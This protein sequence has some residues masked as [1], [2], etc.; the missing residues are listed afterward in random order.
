ME[1]RWLCS[2]QPQ[3][4]AHGEG[5]AVADNA[6]VMH[7]GA[8]GATLPC[9]CWSLEAR[10]DQEALGGTKRRSLGFYEVV[11]VAIVVVVIVVPVAIRV[12]EESPYLLHHA[13]AQVH[14]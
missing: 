1:E 13:P 9:I 3:H 8:S 12:K 6:V 11:I 2:G 7:V 4:M 5:H 14:S 10:A